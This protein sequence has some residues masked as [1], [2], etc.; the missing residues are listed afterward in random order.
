[1]HKSDEDSMGA[2][3]WSIFTMLGNDNNLIFISCYRVCPHSPQ[4]SPGGA[5]FQQSRI[6]E[7][8]VEPIPFT[9]DPHRQTIRDLQMFIAS[10]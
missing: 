9:I 2:G 3:R 10:Y 4:S 7:D 8:K 6:M 1:V 5:Y